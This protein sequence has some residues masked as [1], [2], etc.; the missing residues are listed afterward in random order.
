MNRENAN[1]Q[2]V[3]VCLLAFRA[4]VMYLLPTKFGISYGV[5]KVADIQPIYA[6]SLRFTLD[7]Y[8]PQLRTAE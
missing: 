2:R 4:V 1:H 6:K 5:E 7:L 3:V 8:S